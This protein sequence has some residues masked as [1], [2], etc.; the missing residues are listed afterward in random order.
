MDLAERLRPLLLRHQIQLVTG[1]RSRCRISIASF[2]TRRDGSR[3]LS[4]NPDLEGAQAYEAA[5][6]FI[7]LVRIGDA[8]RRVRLNERECQAGA[9]IE[10]SRL[11]IPENAWALGQR[12]RWNDADLL[13]HYDVT[14]RLFEARKIAWRR[15]LGIAFTAGAREF[16]RSIRM[17]GSSFWC[18]IV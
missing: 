7:G 4:I 11:A 13:E 5:L 15:S 14:W 3:Q 1:W 8:R 2:E 16:D 17:R 10:A 9:W 18:E 6:Y 12:L